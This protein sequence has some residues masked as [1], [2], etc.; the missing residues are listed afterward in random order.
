MYYKAILC[1]FILASNVKFPCVSLC[2]GDT[3][4]LRVN[5]KS[6]RTTDGNIYLDRA[7]GA[8]I[9]PQSV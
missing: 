9:L 5:S 7:N 2:L 3:L 1:C 8:L 4:C 6:N